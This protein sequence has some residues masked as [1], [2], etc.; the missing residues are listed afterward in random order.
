[1]IKRIAKEDYPE[2]CRWWDARKFPNVPAEALPSTGYMVCDENGRGI[3]AGFLYLMQEGTFGWLE[4]VTSNP[5]ILHDQKQPALVELMET[6]T[7]IAGA[8][9]VKV[10]I[11]AADRTK[12]RWLDRLTQA[13]FFDSGETVAHMIR[14]IPKT[15]DSCQHVEQ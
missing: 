4:F 11:T 12:P 9:G 10:L 1:M 5:D 15:E 7:K 14:I 3:W 8:M 13:G 2:I 6:V